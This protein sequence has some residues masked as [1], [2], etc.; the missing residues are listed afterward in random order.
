M[1]ELRSHNGADKYEVMNQIHEDV[2]II[3]SYD[4]EMKKRIN[5]ILLKIGNYENVEKIWK[6]RVHKYAQMEKI[7]PYVKFELIRIP[8]SHINQEELDKIFNNT[9]YLERYLKRKLN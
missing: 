3:Y 7:L 1:L 9:G 8:Q 5:Y 2:G 4:V 6:D